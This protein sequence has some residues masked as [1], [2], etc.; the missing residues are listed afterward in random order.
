MSTFQERFARRDDAV[1]HRYDY[2][3]EILLVADLGPGR[4]GSVDILGDT[5]IVVFDDEQHEFEIPGGDARGSLVN[6]VLTVE[7]DR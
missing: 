2:D 4:E 6:G 1:A 3:E 7:V 5:A